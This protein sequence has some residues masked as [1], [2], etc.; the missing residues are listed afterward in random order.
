MTSVA[1]INIFFEAYIELALYKKK[2][3]NLHRNN[4][5]KSA[6]KLPEIKLI[7]ITERTNLSQ[8]MNPSTAKI[9]P[10]VQKYFQQGLAAKIPHRKNPGITFSIYTEYE[11]DFTGN[12]T[13]FL[14]EEVTSLEQV[15]EGFKTLVIPAQAYT[16]FTTLPGPMPGVVIDAWQKIWSMTDQELA[17][18]RAY[19]ADFELYDERASDPHNVIVDLYIGIHSM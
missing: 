4:M 12:Y 10:T 6:V 17:G 13:Y 2:Y 1:K 9:G 5:L 14:G 7:G 8:E 19:C 16:K 18:K 3:S 15:P 11:S